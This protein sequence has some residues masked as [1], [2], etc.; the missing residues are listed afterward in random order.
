MK[1]QILFIKK[2]YPSFIINIEL[3]YIKLQTYENIRNHID[4]Q[5][6]YIFYRKFPEKRKQAFLVDLDTVRCLNY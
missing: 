5:F 4:S 1:N 3:N 6:G 2:I